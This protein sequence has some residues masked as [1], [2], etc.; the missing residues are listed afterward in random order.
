M[1]T[2]THAETYLVLLAHTQNIYELVY[3]HTQKYTHMHTYIHTWEHLLRYAHTY[4]S[5]L[6]DTGTHNHTMHT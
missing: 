1:H 6:T 5:V 2:H 4:V 3:M